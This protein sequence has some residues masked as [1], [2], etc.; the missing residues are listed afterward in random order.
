MFRK[1]MVTLLCLA[2]LSAT[3]CTAKTPAQEPESTPGPSDAQTE[4]TPTPAQSAEP[5]EPMDMS[6]V[7][8]ALL[9]MEGFSVKLLQ[10]LKNAY[11]DRNALFSP[12][13]LNASMASLYAAAEGD[14]E[15]EL[16]LTM[17]YLTEPEDTVSTLKELI[18]AIDGDRFSLG[19]SLHLS[20]RVG[21]SEKFIDSVTAPLRIGTYS[22]D[23]ADQ[24]TFQS[25]NACAELLTNGKVSSVLTSTA[26]ADT[27]YL[28]TAFNLTASFDAAFDPSATKPASFETPMGLVATQMMSGDFLTGYAEDEYM[29]MVSLPME[30]GSIE[31]KL[32]LPREGGEAAFDEALIQYADQWLSQEII[33]HTAQSVFQMLSA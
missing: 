26:A 31:L 13:G 9:Q 17:G 7:S 24:A 4:T 1:L 15:E 22:Q 10:N 12:L 18:T 28:I 11:T 6:R 14:T 20:K 5:E 33:T 23:Y 29:Q 32:I 3:A 30:G 8:D 2:L 19:N 27:L 21:F 16:R 25:I